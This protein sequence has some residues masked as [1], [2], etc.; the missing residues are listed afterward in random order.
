M[1]SRIVRTALIMSIVCVAAGAAHAAEHAATAGNALSGSAEAIF[2][3][4]IALLLLIGRGLG[5]IMQ[6]IGQPSVIGQ[7]L[8]GLVLGPSV[9][10]WLFPA[11]HHLIF[12]DSTTQK[13]LL[14]GLSNIGVMVLLLLTGM[15]TDLAGA[16]EGHRAAVGGRVALSWAD[17]CQRSGAMERRH[18]PPRQLITFLPGGE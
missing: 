1:N 17:D 3:A 13:S 9:F 5:E 4:Q 12:P 14:A 11:A 8:A 10:G 18:R 15:E 6:K 2:V 16:Q 7:L